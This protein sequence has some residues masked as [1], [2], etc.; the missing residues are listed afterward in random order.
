[1]TDPRKPIETP[2]EILQRL[3]GLSPREAEVLGLLVK[4]D[5]MQ[6]VAARLGIDIETVRS[7]VKHIMDTTGVSRQ[8]DL[9]RLVMSSPAWLAG[10]K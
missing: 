7:H 9:V 4:G 1:M 10:G 3:F 8:A 5:D 6:A 2:Q